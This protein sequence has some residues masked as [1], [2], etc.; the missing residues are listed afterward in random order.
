MDTFFV[1]KQV[2]VGAVLFACLELTVL[3]FKALAR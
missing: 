1:R 2:V 3:L